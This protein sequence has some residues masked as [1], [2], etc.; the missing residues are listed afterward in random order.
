MWAGVD[1]TRFPAITLTWD[2]IP[3]EADRNGRNNREGQMEIS[4]HYLYIDNAVPIS[5]LRKARIDAKLG[6]DSRM[7]KS[8][9]RHGREAGR[10]VQSTCDREVE[11]EFLRRMRS[12]RIRIHPPDVDPLELLPENHAPSPERERLTCDH[13]NTI[14]AQW[15]QCADAVKKNEHTRRHFT[16]LLPTIEARLR[17]E[18]LEK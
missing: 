6:S 10:V 4:S 14:K 11:G 16:E 7:V 8:Y 18:Q 9:N 3:S 12:A 2:N 13:L 5:K 15:C 1:L 17:R